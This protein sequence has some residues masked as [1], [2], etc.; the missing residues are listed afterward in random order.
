[1]RI[2]SIS[3]ALLLSAASLCA[4]AQASLPSVSSRKTAT[5]LSVDASAYGLMPYSMATDSP[6]LGHWGYGV[7]AGIEYE[8][9]IS[10][11]FRLE[12]S[13]FDIS[14]SSVASTGE[15]YKAWDGL[16]IA[17]LSGYSFPPIAL[18]DSMALVFSLLGGGAITAAEYSDTANAYAYPSIIMEARALLAFGAMPLQDSGPWI[19]IPAEFMFRA[20]NYTLSPGLSLGW[21]YKIMESK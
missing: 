2:R 4:G 3:L 13:Y 14:R 8:T 18:G 7:D 16:K 21:R 1:M 6:V 5:P 12:L 15:L 9:V 19:A 17:L 11:P 20:G 10:V